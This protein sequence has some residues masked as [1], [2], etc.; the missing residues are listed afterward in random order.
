[1]ENRTAYIA[2]GSNLGDREATLNRALRMM[3]Q[4]GDIEVRRVSHWFETQPAGGP[5]GQGKYLNGVAEVVTAL[6]PPALLAELQQIENALGRDRPREERWG[7]RTC[8]LDILLMGD[9]VL[10]TPELTIPHPRMHERRFVLEPLAEIAAGLVHPVMKKTV[11]ALLK[12]L[13]GHR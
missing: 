8:D 12:E 11:L 9:L 1:M 10:D 5:P 2:L 3:D 7:P 4:T 13:G 6:E